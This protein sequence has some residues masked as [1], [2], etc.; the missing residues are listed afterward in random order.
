MQMHYQV[1]INWYS[2]SAVSRIVLEG[3]GFSCIGIGAGT[4]RLLEGQPLETSY[5][6]D[7]YS[8]IFGSSDVVSDR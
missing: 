2:P 7:L 5:G 4:F 3:V 1:E 6:E 8:Q